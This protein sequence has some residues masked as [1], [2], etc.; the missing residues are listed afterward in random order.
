MAMTQYHRVL[1]T[2]YCCPYFNNRILQ[3]IIAMTLDLVIYCI[4][5]SEENSI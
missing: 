5:I 4:Y 1:D 3:K 2:D